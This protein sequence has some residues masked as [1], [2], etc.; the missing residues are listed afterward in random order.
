MSSGV[1]LLASAVM[2]FGAGGA[3]A[4]T[5]LQVL[6]SVASSYNLFLSGDMGSS[7]S[8]ISYS[9]VEGRV[10]VGGSAYLRGYSIGANT[11]GGVGLTVGQNLN[12]NSGTIYGSVAVG[13]NAT[14]ANAAVNG[15]VSTGGALISPPSTYV[16]TAPYTVPSNY[17]TSTAASLQAAS[18]LLDSAA[19]QA[20]GTV[21][22]VSN[23]YGTLNLTSNATGVVFFDLA[24]SQLVGINGLNFNVNSGAT[25]V[26]NVTG[27][28]GGSIGNFGFQGNYQ[29]SKT[30]FN[31]VDA[32][33]LSLSNLGYQASILAPKATIAFN[34]GQ[35]NGA[36]MAKAWTGGA[37]VN[38]AAFTGD[39]LAVGGGVPEPG[40]WTMMLMGL[41]GMGATLRGVRRKTAE[42]TSA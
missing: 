41:F 16:G 2:A 5:S 9:D 29:T 30:L 10:A 14:F 23:T 12:F 28:V 22:N 24:G 17:F 13:G 40:V 11:P 3:H 20:K 34:N 4:T 42:A 1:A 27:P 25:V 7:S 32:T 39:L 26:V 31:F 19:T 38:E 6:S 15:V 21:G 18:A 8:P 33:L 35:T 37:Q 36:V